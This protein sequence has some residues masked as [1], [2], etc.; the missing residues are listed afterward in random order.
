MIIDTHSH[1]GKDFYFK[2]SKL[3][4]YDDFCN[5][6]NIDIGFLMPMPWPVYKKDST[7][8]CSLVWEHENYSLIHYYKLINNG[9]N[10]EKK[11]VTSNPY[12][13]VNEYYYNLIKNSNT[14]TKIKFIPLLHGVL[15][16]PKYLDELIKNTKPI[17]VKFHGFSGC[18]FKDDIKFDLIEILKYYDIPVILHTS[19]YNYN[20]GYG[21]GT[22]FWRNKCSP[23]DWIDFLIK[24][25]LRGVLNHGACLDYDVINMINKSNNI[26]IGLGPDLDISLDPYKVAI[27]K[28]DYLKESY[29]ELLKKMACSEKILFDL[30][31]NWNL[32][33]K[34]NLDYGSIERINKVWSYSDSERILFKNAKAF[35]K[36]N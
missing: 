18:F 17:A 33:G 26:M 27:S 4:S 3:S 22:K 12:K 28:E 9:Q 25:E 30:D 13:E 6:N 23:K 24:N 14:K 20:D 2:E 5:K 35:Y 7:E 36:L 29:L 11:I 15:D 16:E 8:I 1:I 21:I 34:G 32:D 10:L 31:Y 19:V